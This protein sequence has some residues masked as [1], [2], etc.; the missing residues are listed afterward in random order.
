MLAAATKRLRR[1]SVMALQQ[2]EGVEPLAA[3]GSGDESDVPQSTLGSVAE[4]AA[5]FVALFD[6]DGDGEGELTLRR[7]DRLLVIGDSGHAGW[8]IGSLV[9]APAVSGIF[10]ADF[11]CEVPATAGAANPYVLPRRVGPTHL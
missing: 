6:F 4:P 10:P 11:V 7:G 9:D 5:T 3:D 2:M 8:W 1:M